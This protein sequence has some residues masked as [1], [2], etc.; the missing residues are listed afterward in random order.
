MTFHSDFLPPTKTLLRR[1]WYS[2]LI[3]SGVLYSTSSTQLKPDQPLFIRMKSDTYLSLCIEQAEMSPLHF[4]HGAIV[5]RGGKVIGHGYNDYRPGFDGV[6]TGKLYTESDHDEKKNNGEHGQ[7]RNK[8]MVFGKSKAQDQSPS[9]EADTFSRSVRPPT[10]HA[11]M[12]AIHSVLKASATLSTTSFSN[13]S[14]F[15]IPHDKRHEAPYAYVPLQP[16]AL[17]HQTL[18]CQREW[19]VQ[20]HLPRSTFLLRNRQEEKQDDLQQ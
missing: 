19:L 7:Y 16:N 1:T 14:Y 5:V 11:E 9:T 8:K 12:M 4:R 20:P 17:S 3:I 2:S 13:R 10:M 15:K 6:A 18:T